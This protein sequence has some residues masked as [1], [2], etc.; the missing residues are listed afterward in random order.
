MESAFGADLSDVKAYRGR[1]ELTELGAEA[2]TAGGRVAFMAAQ[3]D[4]E[5]VAH[6]IV[7]VAQQRHEGEIQGGRSGLSEPSE[8]AELE[9]DEVAAGFRSG[10]RTLVSAKSSGTIDR[11][12]LDEV[13]KLFAKATHLVQQQ[14]VATIIDQGLAITPDPAKGISDPDYLLHNTCQWIKANN[15][16]VFVFTQIHDATTRNPGLI[17]YFDATVKYPNQGGDYPADPTVVNDP[18]IQYEQPGTLGG[19][20]PGGLRLDIIDPGSTSDADLKATMIHEV[21]HDADQTWP[22]QRWADPAGSATNDYQ[23]EFRA[24][25]IESGEHSPNDT[26]GSSGSP[27]VNTQQVSFTDP[28]SGTTTSVATNFKNL[29]QENIFWHLVNT[30]YSYV[31]QNYVQ[32]AAFKTMVDAFDTPTGGNLVNSVRIQTLSDRLAACS[33][34]MDRSAA[35]VQAMFTAADGLDDLDRQYLR[36]ET[37]SAS[38]WTQAATALASDIYDMLHNTVWFKT[39]EA[40]GDFPEPS[41]KERSLA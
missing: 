27:A 37:M 32:V 4:Q 23:S 17:G 29:R 18:H 36:D 16:E 25:W 31:N 9:A 1:S 19:L 41:E 34:S 35:A 13:Q 26:Y 20:Q 7:H 3:P 28:A 10:D 2:A 6:E 8:P 15:C 12:I 24:Y 5:V 21:Q 40:W 22:G 38:F 30:G 14:R 39:R 11:S 33:T